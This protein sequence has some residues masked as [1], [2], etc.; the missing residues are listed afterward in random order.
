[1][2]CQLNFTTA[3][4]YLLEV[5]VHLR[6]TPVI[7]VGIISWVK[8]VA[9]VRRMWTVIAGSMSTTCA[10][11]GAAM[12]QIRIVTWIKLV[13][14]VR[15]MGTIVGGSMSTASTECGTTMILITIVA[16]IQLVADI[17]GMWP[18]N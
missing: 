17:G 6:S 3:G 8:L 14:N 7:K 5:I 4:L 2:P 15:R 11:G 10:V 12:I 18:V 1:M 16:R 9:N 13:S